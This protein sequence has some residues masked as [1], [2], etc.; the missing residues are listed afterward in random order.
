MNQRIYRTSVWTG[1]RSRSCRS[2]DRRVGALCAIGLVLLGFCCAT[3]A[4]MGSIP[5]EPGI[6]VIE[7]TQRALIACSGKEEILILSTDLAADRNTKVLEV[8]PFPSEPKVTKADASIFSRVTELINDKF[9]WRDPRHAVYSM[10]AGDAAA[11]ERRKPPAG[12]IT[13]H[14]RIGAH[15][16]SVAHVERPADFV[17]WARDYLRSQGVEGPV[18]PPAL[19][20]VVEDYIEDNFKWFVFDVVSLTT[21]PRS[22]DAIQ[23][24]FPCEFLY[25]PL[26]ITRTEHGD[27]SVTLLIVTK[28]LLSDKLCLGFPRKRIAVVHKPVRFSAYELRSISEEIH[29]MLGEPKSVAVRNWRIEGELSSFNDDVI[30]GDPRVVLDHVRAG[31]TRIP[32]KKPE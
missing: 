2:V 11:G 25:Y 9:D 18:I 29:T 26:R 7:P 23:F 22:K 31:R 27:T 10:G 32:A 13:F 21:K 12:R 6:R 20:A 30:F 24:R 3:L 1:A 8:M 28:F 17:E 16:I 14:E 15:D 5:F 19:A 4:D